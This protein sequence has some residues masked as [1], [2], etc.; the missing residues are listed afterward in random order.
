MAQVETV[1]GP[2]EADQLGTTLVHEHLCVRDEAVLVQWPDAGTTQEQEP[3][4]VGPG[5][6]REVATREAKAAV[7]L[8]VNTICDPSA[9]FL[10]RDVELMR[11]ASE[12]SGLQVVPATGIYT[13]DHLPQYLLNRDPDQIA[14]LFIGDI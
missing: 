11:E 6:E 13:Y 5:E 14:E 8:G 1:S 2:I 10:G 3:H 4:A 9:L 7:E 12:K